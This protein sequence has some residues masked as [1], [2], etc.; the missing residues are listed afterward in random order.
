MIGTTVGKYRIV[1]QLG[2]GGAGVVYRAVDET[3]HRDVAIK[4]LDPELA[5]TEVMNRFRAEATILARL[6]HPH[7]ATIYELFKAERELLMVME[8]VRGEALDKLSERL[9]PMAPD[10]AGY[11]VDL[12]LS[13]LEHAHRAGVVHRD[14]KPANVMVTVEGSVKIM[15][16]GIARVFGAEQKT[17]DFRLMG[18]PAYMSPEQVLGEEVDGRSDLYSVGVLFYRLLTGALPFAADTALGMLQRQIRDT[19]IPLAAHRVGLPP[20]CEDVVQR[21]LA[22]TPGERFQ[23][24]EEFRDALAKATGPLPSADLARTFA[25]RDLVADAPVVSQTLDLRHRPPDTD[26]RTAAAVVAPPAPVLAWTHVAALAIVAAGAVGLGYVVLSD[27]RDGAVSASALVV[28]PPP[29]APTATAAEA[30]PAAAESA[31]VAAPA[32]TSE[33]PPAVIT[34]PPPVRRT[35]PRVVRRLEPVIEAESEPVAAPSPS[36]P[37]VPAVPPLVPIAVPPAVPPAAALPVD[38]GQRVPP[39]EAEPSLVFETKALVGTRRPREQSAQLVLGDGKITIIPQEDPTTPLCS[40]AYRRVLAI[41]VSRSRDPLWNSP[42]G[43]APVARAG[44]ALSRLGIQVSRDWIAIRTSTEE[45]F[46]AMRF[47]EVVLKRVLLALE[48]RTGR[49]SQFIALPSVRDTQRDTQ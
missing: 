24:A 46:V 37:S 26:V 35:V 11:V 8:L 29:S 32:V 47:D 43:P 7:I 34:A 20:W 42:S 39:P 9:G 33:V 36:A 18:T 38:P 49:R 17:V 4:T 31:A 5:N 27:D 14:V 1:G 28:P 6:N 25:A 23:S 21:A 15:D 22:K 13:A 44:G 10:R 40:F 2:R 45:Q 19:P 48:E 3:L 41:N 30:Q 16:F 12:V